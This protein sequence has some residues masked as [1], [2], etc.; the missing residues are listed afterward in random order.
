MGQEASYA[1][2]EAE[3]LKACEGLDRLLDE[4]VMVVTE[5][6]CALEN[7]NPRI[8]EQPQVLDRKTRI[9]ELLDTLDMLTASHRNGSTT[10]S[11]IRPTLVGRHGA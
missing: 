11:P 4:Y 2:C 8:M 10:D 9:L 5:G 1:A 3:V 6:L 7:E